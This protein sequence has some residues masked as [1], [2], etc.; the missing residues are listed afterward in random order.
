[1]IHV[2]KRHQALYDEHQAGT[3]TAVARGHDL[4]SGQTFERFTAAAIRLQLLCAK[5]ST[6]TATMTMTTARGRVPFVASIGHPAAPRCGALPAFPLWV[7]DALHAASQAERRQNRASPLA[8]TNSK[9]ARRHHSSR[10]TKSRRCHPSVCTPCDEKANAFFDFPVVLRTIRRSPRRLPLVSKPC[11]TIPRPHS[12]QVT[13][14]TC[15]G[16]QRAALAWC[17]GSRIGS[18]SSS[19]SSSAPSSLDFELSVGFM[20]AQGSRSHMTFSKTLA[21]AQ[22]LENKAGGGGRVTFSQT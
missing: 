2:R 10:P 11:R 21:G 5:P 14:P 15:A 3:A 7:R 22:P 1:M 20:H 9:M 13:V 16:L 18:R 8:A 17:A 4:T 19:A 6:F 12:K